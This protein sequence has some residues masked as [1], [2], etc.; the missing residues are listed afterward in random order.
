VAA[1]LD[2]WLAWN[3]A[4]PE[5]VERRRIADE[6]GVSPEALYRQL[7][8]RRRSSDRMDRV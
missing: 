1:R 6:I 3:N 8:K 5:K 4:L 7:G 2:A